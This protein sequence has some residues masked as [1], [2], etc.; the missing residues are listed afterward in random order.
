MSSISGLYQEH[1]ENFLFD[2]KKTEINTLE[3]V[4][5]KENEQEKVGRFKLFKSTNKETPNKYEGNFIDPWKKEGYLVI[6]FFND[7][8]F[9]ALYSSDPK[10]KTVIKKLKG[11]KI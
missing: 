10:N 1:L 9:E 11:V 4:Y 6:S 8:T 2:I 5:Y 7:G 3:G